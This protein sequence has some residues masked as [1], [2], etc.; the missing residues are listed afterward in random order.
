MT[1]IGIAA[2][3]KL[4]ELK[5]FLRVFVVEW[6]VWGNGLAKIIIITITIYVIDDLSMLEL[7]C[8]QFYITRQ[9]AYINLSIEITI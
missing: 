1:G 8:V 9:I 7:P 4:R 2:K 3:T 6:E 5:N